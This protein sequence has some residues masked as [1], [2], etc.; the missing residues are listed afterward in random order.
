M[1]KSIFNKFNKESEDS[2]VCESFK[3]YFDKNVPRVTVR[4]P[5]LSKTQIKAKIKQLW[6][7]E[8]N[9]KVIGVW[10]NNKGQK[11]LKKRVNFAKK[12][13]FFH[14]DVIDNKQ[15]N[16]ETHSLTQ[17]K[18]ETFDK[19][20]TPETAQSKVCRTPFKEVHFE[21][22]NAEDDAFVYSCSDS[23]D[24]DDWNS[25]LMKY[26]DDQQQPLD[27]EIENKKEQPRNTCMPDTSEDLGSSDKENEPPLESNTILA[28]E[29]MGGIEKVIG[30]ELPLVS[31]T[32]MEVESCGGIMN[33]TKPKQ[34]TPFRKKEKDRKRI[35]LTSKII[36]EIETLAEDSDNSNEKN[37][38]NLDKESENLLPRNCERGNNGTVGEDQNSSLKEKTPIANSID[39]FSTDF[40]DDDETPVSATLV[41]RTYS[42][43][44]YSKI[45]KE[46]TMYAISSK[47]KDEKKDAIIESD[48]DS[49]FLTGMFAKPDPKLSGQQFQ[50]RSLFRKAGGETQKSIKDFFHSTSNAENIFI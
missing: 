8:Q 11:L 44:K 47:T 42:A 6:S 43:R 27:A 32:I 3:Q 12:P 41:R 29:S 39:L 1:S 18:K 10:K 35:P 34:D 45:K 5:F 37:V 4:Y 28:V 14:L 17:N 13:E 24:G 23:E 22:E 21:V 9:R 19:F 25:N 49:G 30:T 7:I 16:K 36:M 31:R 15:E 50:G 2:N 46:K 48:G 33:F 26:E 20:D 38:K 40:Q